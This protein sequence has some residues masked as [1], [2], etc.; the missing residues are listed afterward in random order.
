MP[1]AIVDPDELRDFVASLRRYT[2]LV[3]NA[4]SALQSQFDQLA[5]TWRDQEQVKFANDFEETVRAIRK[6]QEASEEHIPFLERK[7]GE[8]D[9]YLDR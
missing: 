6:F 1:Q 8:I 4:T 2:D 7:A 3:S 9:Q 5:Q